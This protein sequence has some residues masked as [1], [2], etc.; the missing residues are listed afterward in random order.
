MPS[1]RFAA[2][3]SSSTEFIALRT[4]PPQA[5]LIL[6]RTPFSIS[7]VTAF[8]SAKMPIARLTA[9]STSY[10]GTCLNSN[11]VERLKIALN[12]QK[13]GFSVVEAMSVIL[14]SSINSS[15]D[16]CCFLLKYC[17]SSRYSSTPP[18]VSNVSSSAIIALMSEMPAVVALSLRNVRL[19]F[20]AI[21]LATVVLPVP[22]GP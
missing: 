2:E 14:P 12:T 10:A 18:G 1:S 5:E 22:D 15:S 21:I 9:G 3:N 8:L 16:C 7:G 19:V 4:S 20:S 11:T 6:R 13:Y 17:I